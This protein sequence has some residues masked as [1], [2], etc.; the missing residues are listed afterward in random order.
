MHKSVKIRVKGLAQAADSGSSCS[1][2]SHY[3]RSVATEI[4]NILMHCPTAWIKLCHFTRVNNTWACMKVFSDFS[5]RT[6]D[7]MVLAD[8]Y[9]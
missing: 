4:L 8:Q 3:S 6:E 9:E 2:S 7:L 5:V 1:P